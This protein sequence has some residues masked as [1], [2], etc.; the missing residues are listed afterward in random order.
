MRCVTTLAQIRTRKNGWKG[1]SKWQPKHSRSARPVTVLHMVGC[2]QHVCLKFGWLKQFVTPGEPIFA[3]A[4]G[5][6]LYIHCVAWRNIQQH[7]LPLT[8]KPFPPCKHS[9][10]KT[11][12]VLSSYA[13][14]P[15]NNGMSQ[16]AYYKCK[17]SNL[18]GQC[19]A[20]IFLLDGGADPT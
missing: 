2:F 16:M 5:I 14:S 15:K 18:R 3:Y 10:L 20:L 8:G 17:S 13:A 11:E 1:E 6:T 12:C 9:S 7:K 19:I 4:H